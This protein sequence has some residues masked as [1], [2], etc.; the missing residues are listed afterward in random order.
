MLKLVAFF[1]TYSTLFRL[2]SV[3]SAALFVSD[4]PCPVLVDQPSVSRDDLH[5]IW[6]EIGRTHLSPEPSQFCN[7]F[8]FL[9]V[10]VPYGGKLRGN[11]SYRQNPF[12]QCKKLIVGKNR[13]FSM[14]SGRVM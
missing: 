2:R 8:T 13:K 14:T 4:P 9:D 11:E 10:K 3:E 6:F 5:G 1:L 12:I 7:V